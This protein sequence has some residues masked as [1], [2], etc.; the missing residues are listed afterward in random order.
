MIPEWGEVFGGVKKV[1]DTY[2]RDSFWDKSS[3]SIDTG[4]KEKIG[5]DSRLMNSLCKM[6]VF[7]YYNI[8]FIN[9]E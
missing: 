3:I 2:G 1:W 6:R 8:C 7:P 9:E 4:R 5:E